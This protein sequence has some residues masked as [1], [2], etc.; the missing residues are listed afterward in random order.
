VVK[1]QYLLSLIVLITLMTTAIA[2]TG[3]KVLVI[4]PAEYP[5]LA[6]QMHVSG[7]VKMEAVVNSNGKVKDVKVVGG[8]P[9]LAVSALHSAKSW[10]FEPAANETVEEISINFKAS[11]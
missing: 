1:K 6:R 3:R 10:Q 2:G 8:H 5:A 7:I 9:L 11:E 4:A